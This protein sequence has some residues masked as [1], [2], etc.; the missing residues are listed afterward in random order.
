MSDLAYAPWTAEQVACLVDRQRDTSRH[1]YTCGN[2]TSLPLVP[3]SEGWKCLRCQ[4]VQVWAHAA[5]TVGDQRW[6]WSA[7]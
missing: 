5:D 2:H 7:L 6:D 1:P 4:Y 3:T